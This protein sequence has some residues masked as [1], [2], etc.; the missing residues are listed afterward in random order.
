MSTNEILK[1]AETFLTRI[2]GV[3]VICITPVDV[4]YTTKKELLD[5]ILAVVSR[6]TGIPEDVILSRSRKM[7]IMTA[8]HITAYLLYLSGLSRGQI[9][10]L[11]NF[12]RS[13]TY[14]SIDFVE[15]QLNCDKN[16]NALFQ[17]IKNE[18]L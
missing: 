10:L 8:R 14:N 12:N 16:F 3:K 18:L 4:A 15:G 7:D 1:Q 9:A 2:C 5:K 11:I 17:T 6:Y 13:T